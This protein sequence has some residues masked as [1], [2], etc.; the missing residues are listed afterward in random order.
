MSLDVGE[1]CCGIY[2][3]TA[4]FNCINL[5]F[6]GGGGGGGGGVLLGGTAGLDLS[7]RF[8]GI[9]FNGRFGLVGLLGFGCEDLIINNTF[10][11]F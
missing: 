8:G 9:G 6:L 11:S 2:Y 7:S 4:Y 3:C 5:F 1:I 10:D